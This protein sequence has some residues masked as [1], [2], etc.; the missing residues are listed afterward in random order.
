MSEN[1]KKPVVDV[2]AS[3]MELAQIIAEAPNAI[4]YDLVLKAEEFLG[5]FI[6]T[7]P[8]ILS[9]KQFKG[10]QQYILKQAI[11]DISKGLLLLRTS[12]IGVISRNGE[13]KPFI[14][15]YGTSPDGSVVFSVNIKGAS[16]SAR[17]DVLKNL[18]E[19]SIN[20]AV[21]KLTV[22]LAKSQKE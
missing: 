12:T 18:N 1:N 21:Y 4:E 16:K 19:D 2:F 5:V 17:E 8:N 11:E 22:V 9:N 7:R 6:D 3:S 13:F 15:P 10:L 20:A 14:S